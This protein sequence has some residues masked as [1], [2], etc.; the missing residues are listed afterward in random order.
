MYCIVEIKG[1]QYKVQPGDLVDVEKMDT[2]AGKTVTLSQV[3]LVGG[4]TSMIGQPTVQ[5]A[6][7]TA[8]V[9]RHGRTRKIFVLKRAPGRYRRKNGHR[10][11]YTGLLITE[12]AD[13]KGGTAKMAKDHKNAKYLK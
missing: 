3:L 11:E 2:E 4:D 6:Q 10:Q 8:K 1:H 9:V 5:G 13:G 12:L 7:V